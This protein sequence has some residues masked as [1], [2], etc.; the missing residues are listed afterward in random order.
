MADFISDDLRN[1]SADDKILSELEKM[2]KNFESFM[3]SMANM[4]QAN[5]KDTFNDRQN[6]FRNQYKQQN[7]W[8]EFAD[9]WN[10]AFG[11]RSSSN[12]RSAAN[13]PKGFLDAFEKELMEGLLGFDLKSEM[14]STLKNFADQLGVDINDLSTEVGKRLGEKAKESISNSSFGKYMQNTAQNL[15]D[16]AQSVFQ[17]G[18]DSLSGKSSSAKD[19]ADAAR[20]SKLDEF[21]PEGKFAKASSAVGGKLGGL[22]TKGASFLGAGEEVAAFAG[23]VGSAIPPLL[24]VTAGLTILDGATEILGKVFE[25]IAASASRTAASREKNMKLAQERLEADV[26]TLVETPFNILK[27]AA[28]QLYD[29][30]DNNIQKI[31]A[32]QG[33]T[34]SDLQA[35]I[36]AY[37]ERA[38]SEGLEKYISSATVTENLAKVLESGL[39]GKLA[40]EFAYQA[41]KLNAAV[42]TQDFFGY[43]SSYAAV[44]ANLLKEGSSQESA[45]AAAN[46]SLEQFASSILYASRELSGGFTTGLRDASALYDEAVKI[47]TAARTGNINDI[48]G[49]L[50][51]I[52]ATIGGIAPD[53]TSSIADAVYNL[54]TGGNSSELVALRSIAG[55]NA[56]NTE[57]LQMFAKNPKGIF[58]TLFTNLGNMYN[59]LAP[60]A[61]MEVAEGL[62]SVFGLSSEAFQRIDFNYLAQQIGAMN[63]STASLNENMSLLKEGQTTLTREQLRTQQVNEYMIEEGLAYVLDSEAGRAIQEHMWQE[64]MMRELQETEYA[65]DLKGKGLE[66]LESIRKVLDILNPFA[67]MK[68]ISNVFDTYAEGSALEKDI[69]AVLEATKVGN[70]NQAALTN[71]LTRNA[72]LQLTPTLAELLTGHSYYKAVGTNDPNSVLNRLALAANSKDSILGPARSAALNTIRHSNL[73]GGSIS[74][75]S[76]FSFGGS[77]GGPTSQYSWG[78]GASKSAANLVSAMLATSKTSSLLT[79]KQARDATNTEKAAKQMRNRLQKMLSDEYLVDKFVKQ[80]KT[81]EEF[82]ASSKK[83]GISNF[84]S[85]LDQ[86]GYNEAQIKSY[87]EQKETQAAGEEYANIRADEK[88]FRDAG[89]QFWRVDFW[90]KYN[91]PLFEQIEIIKENYLQVMI[92]NQNAWMELWTKDFTKGWMTQRWDD[93]FWKQYN[94]YYFEHKI[95]D[96]GTLKLDNLQKVQS[97]EKAEKGDVVN[98]LAEQLTNNAQKLDDLKDPTIQTNAILSQILIVVDAIMNQTARTQGSVSLIDSLSALATGAT[99]LVDTK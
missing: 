87:F 30:W 65:V 6:H 2:N 49:V 61:Y 41:T 64:Q 94:D 48:A 55:I 95:Y 54:A 43:A 10:S 82:A 75:D 69:G 28:Q 33:Y 38:R 67:W 59:T 32:T 62:S 96:G 89:R 20:S 52:S 34:K 93:K 18:I 17:K 25:G 5:A 15:K 81:Y 44:A 45:I 57:F 76:I 53:L 66:I 72:N 71:L 97:K 21:V 19:V 1:T 83:F 35:L 36:G 77:S 11:R 27:D 14:Q 42:P 46:S 84:K 23:A 70:G 60:Q 91:D 79:G 90:E 31:N 74:N 4:S 99:P 9:P 63:V 88:D 50:T 51:S 29:A 68:K 39:S 47:S 86:A 26:K 40:E 80:N 37:A 24:A 22:A 78:G 73:I 7:G 85:A 8:D 16:S 92:D 58:Q 56:S 3:D 98:A 13:G 12:M